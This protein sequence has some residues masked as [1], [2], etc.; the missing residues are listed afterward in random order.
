MGCEREEWGVTA[1]FLA[2]RPDCHL[3][4]LGGPGQEAGSGEVNQDPGF[5]HGTFDGD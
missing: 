5:G 1:G 2:A 3:L 4:M